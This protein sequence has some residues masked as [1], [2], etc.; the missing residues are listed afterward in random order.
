MNAFGDDGRGIWVGLSSLGRL[1]GS[2]KGLMGLMSPRYL[3]GAVQRDFDFLQHAISIGCNSRPNHRHL[4]R[5][6]SSTL[7]WRSLAQAHRALPPLSFLHPHPPSLGLRLDGQCRPNGLLLRCLQ[8]CRRSCSVENVAE[9]RGMCRGDR[10]RTRQTQPGREGPSQTGVLE[11]SGRRDRRGRLDQRGRRKQSRR[12]DR[13]E[14]NRGQ[15]YHWS[16]SSREGR[17]ADGRG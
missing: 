10:Q 6:P 13:V 15:V 9:S 3:L 4:P 16:Q 14:G 2:I 1:K 12:E 17:E 7:L 11:G 8:S 5:P